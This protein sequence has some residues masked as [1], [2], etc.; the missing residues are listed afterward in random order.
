MRWADK[1]Q[2]ARGA[3]R[4][5][6]AL[7]WGARLRLVAR[8]LATPLFPPRRRRAWRAESRALRQALADLERESRRPAE[9]SHPP[10]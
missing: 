3:R 8:A 6:A 1:R 4:T 5:A 2:S 9:S 10:R 7:A